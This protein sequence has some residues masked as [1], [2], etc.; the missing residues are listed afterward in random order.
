[1]GQIMPKEKKNQVQ[2]INLV[3]QVISQDTSSVVS[4]KE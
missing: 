1:M 3:I 2:D 4:L